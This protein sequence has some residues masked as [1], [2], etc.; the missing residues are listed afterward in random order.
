LPDG[1]HSEVQLSVGEHEAVDQRAHWIGGEVEGASLIAERVE[2]QLDPIV[3]VQAGVSPSACRSH[4]RV[5]ESIA[6]DA[7]DKLSSSR[8]SV[9]SVASVGDCRERADAE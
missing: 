3:G 2:Q 9:T 4:H 8:R 7:D 1:I 5:S 6:L